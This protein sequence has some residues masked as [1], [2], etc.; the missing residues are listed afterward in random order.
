MGNEYEGI[1]PY[2]N[3][4]NGDRLFWFVHVYLQPEGLPGIEGVNTW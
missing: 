2:A 1:R 4:T 3:V